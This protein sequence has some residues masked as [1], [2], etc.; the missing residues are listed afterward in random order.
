MDEGGDAFVAHKHVSEK[1]GCLLREHRLHSAV[2]IKPEWTTFLRRH[3]AKLVE[4]QPGGG[5]ILHE[6]LGL[7]ILQHALHL[8]EH[9]GRFAQFVFGGK[10]EERFI[11][12][13]RPQEITEARSQRIGVEVAGVFAQVQK[14]RRTQQRRVARLQRTNGAGLVGVAHDLL[15]CGLDDG[16]RRA[17]DAR[18]APSQAQTVRPA[19]GKILQPNGVRAL[20][21]AHLAALGGGAVQAVVLDDFLI[22]DQQPRA[23][24]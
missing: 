5:E 4:P 20:G 2:V 13:R 3:F 9:H 24:V 22:G 6:G 12:H 8:R 14:A 19:V 23:V 1:R 16:Q 10:A 11:R 18:P 7:G 17:R 15:R 21:Q